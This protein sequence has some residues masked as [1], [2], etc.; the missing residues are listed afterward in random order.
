MRYEVTAHIYEDGALENLSASC[1][2]EIDAPTLLDSHDKAI[3]DLRRLF[4]T[5]ACIAV[6]AKELEP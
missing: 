3:A 2:L 6:T 5:S 4:P 1:R